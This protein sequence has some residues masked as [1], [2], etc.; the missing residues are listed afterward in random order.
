MLRGIIDGVLAGI[1]V[2]IGGTVLLSC[3][4]RVI[5]AVLFSI[6]LLVICYRGYSLY[7]GKIGYIILSHTRKD[8]QTLLTGFSGNLIGTALC[9]FAVSY[10]LPDRAARAAAM[11]ANK[12]QIAYPAVL[13][14]AIF[15]GVLMYLAVAIWKDSHSPLGIFFCVPVFILS[16][17]EHSIANLF[18]FFAAGLWSGKGIRFLFM[19]LLG[20][21]VGGMLFPLL[22]KLSGRY[23]SES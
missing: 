10:A 18:Y 13:I 1:L 7:T 22:G 21:T 9:G 2:S 19:V 17:F 12:M 8:M 5:G 15:C 20:N 16:G 11:W 3:E 6:A 4:N 23:R 14:R